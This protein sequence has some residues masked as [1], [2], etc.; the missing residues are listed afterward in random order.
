[1]V[2]SV[3]LMDGRVISLPI[4]SAATSKEVCKAVS[5]KLK[6]YDI[7]GFSLYMALYDKVRQ[8]GTTRYS[9]VIS[10]Y[11]TVFLDND[12]VCSQSQ[13]LTRPLVSFCT[14]CGLWATDATM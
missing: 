1:M 13:S 11:L 14:R 7:F 2:I 10:G 6:L 12:R 5:K 4:D 9:L 8:G 3:T